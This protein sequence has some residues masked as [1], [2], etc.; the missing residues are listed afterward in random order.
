MT[1]RMCCSQFSIYQIWQRIFLLICAFKVIS[2]SAT[3]PQQQTLPQVYFLGEQHDNPWHHKSRA[4]YLRKLIQN[5]K[6]FAVIFEQVQNGIELNKDEFGTF[7]EFRQRLHWDESWGDWDIYTPLL[8]VVYEN[9]S[10]VIGAGILRSEFQDIEKLSAIRKEIQCFRFPDLSKFEQSLLMSELFENHCRA[11]P[12]SALGP[13]VQAQIL[14][15]QWIAVKTVQTVQEGMPLVV[16]IAG[17]GH[18]R[19]DRGAAFFLQAVGNQQNL[20]YQQRSHGWVEVDGVLPT[21]EDFFSRK[22]LP[23]DQI[24]LSREHNREDPCDIF[25]RERKS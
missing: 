12:R 5:K 8:R 23:F 4:K 2:C 15:D 3:F 13:M 11:I 20:V 17:N 1:S 10:K 25:K 18:I 19:T 16:V 9:A 7:E 6:A 22:K 14:R 24:N 21:D